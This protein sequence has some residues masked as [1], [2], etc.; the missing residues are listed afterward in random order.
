MLIRILIYCHLKDQNPDRSINFTSLEDLPQPE[1]DDFHSLCH[2]AYSGFLNC[3]KQRHLVFYLN[4]LNTLGLMQKEFQVLV[5]EG[6]D[7]FAYSFL[8]L[9]I[10]EFLAAYH[11]HLMAPHEIQDHFDRYNHVIAFSVMILFLAGLTRLQSISLNVPPDISHMNIFHQLYETRDDERI[12]EILSIKDQARKVSR[13]LPIPN[14]Q[15]MFLLGYCIALSQ[16]TWQFSFTL[17]HITDEHFDMFISGLTNKDIQ[18]R[19][20]IEDIS[21]SLNPLGNKGITSLL[22]LPQHVLN[23]LF[24]LRLRGIGVDV[25]CLDELIKK[26]PHLCKLQKMIFRNNHFKSGEQQPLIS[27]I[28]QSNV[29]QHVSFSNL[30]PNECSMLLNDLKSICTLEMC[31]LSP[32]SVEAVVTCLSNASNLETL[33]ICQSEV[34]ADS[35]VYL[36]KTLPS[37]HLKSL[38]FVNCAI[39]SVTVRIIADA[40]I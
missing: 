7:T 9:T 21:V 26:W 1:L 25:G 10:Q 33:Q 30:S 32:P 11:I 24:S 35:I 31:Q 16:C 29:L 5:S 18:P 2:L 4:S 34:K 17:R 8:H 14:T 39:D 12:S 23:N 15:E 36:P 22:C 3:Q 40:V 6:S 13:V 27:A 37:S 28:C 19:Y 20:H 38:E